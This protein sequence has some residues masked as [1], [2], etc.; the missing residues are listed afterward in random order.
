[1]AMT[2]HGWAQ[3]DSPLIGSPWL[4]QANDYPAEGFSVQQHFGTRLLWQEFIPTADFVSRVDLNIADVRVWPALTGNVVFTL[5]N[6]D[7]VELNSVT[8]PVEQITPG[9]WFSVP[10]QSAVTPGSVYRLVINQGEVLPSVRHFN[11]IKATTGSADPYPGGETYWMGTEA[12]LQFRVFGRSQASKAHR[13]QLDNVSVRRLLSSDS[14]MITGFVIE[15]PGPRQVMI[16]GIGP[17][18]REFGVNNTMDDPV[19]T[20][21]D[22]SNEM[23]AQNDD[24]P[25]SDLQNEIQAAVGAFRL[26]ATQDAAIVATLSPGAY[27]AHLRSSDDS[28]GDALIEVYDATGLTENGPTEDFA[29]RPVNLS[30][31]N[32]LAA[33]EK[34]IVGFV[35]GSDR[36]RLVIVRAI[37]PSLAEFGVSPTFAEPR[38]TVFDAAGNVVAENYRFW[39]RNPEL[40]EAMRRAGA[41]TP[42]SDKEA[43]VLLPLA[44]GAYTVHVE[45][46]DGSAGEVLTE[47]YDATDLKFD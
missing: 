33:N 29:S 34:L 20:V 38:F 28:G 41:F 12:D 43:M 16:R 24:H 3:D 14:R 39:D 47:I 2:G 35:I 44:P 21:F 30:T 4:D 26:T 23:V 18:L 45:S 27:T 9:S 32:L 6:S 7:G 25:N 5:E 31:R 40:V 10:V 42:T 11:M 17:S 8:I 15:G 37:S 19:L 1:M 36:S 46:S 22:S 13:R